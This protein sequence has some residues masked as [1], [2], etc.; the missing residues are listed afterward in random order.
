MIG[1]K[2]QAA[3][4]CGLERKTIYGWKLAREMRLKTK[5]KILATLIESVTEETLD[6][7]VQRSTEASADVVRIYLT[8]LYEKA[9]DENITSSEC[10]RLTS[11]FDQMRQK[12][13]GLIVDRLEIEVGNMLRS[14]IERANELD[15]PF[16]P[17]PI[18]IVRL[19][20]FAVLVPNL[21]RTISTISPY[22][23]DDEI[24]QIFNLPRE[25]VSTMSTA[26]HDNY[27]SIRALAPSLR[28]EP[29]HNR[30][31]MKAIGTLQEEREGVWIQVPELGLPT[32]RA[33]GG[34]I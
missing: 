34:T 19:R 33:H 12:Y 30:E 14:I 2:A 26:L 9:M 3:R 6:F 11:K 23:P 28:F 15:M 10:I 21:I 13:A 8:A 22:T 31:Y 32:L 24:A 1:N 18:N 25:F 20:E 17:S 7:I 29:L 16:S 5:K 4:M 27:V